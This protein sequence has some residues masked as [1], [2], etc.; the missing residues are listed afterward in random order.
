VG[1]N[2]ARLRYAAIPLSVLVLSLRNWRPLLPALIVLGLAI[3][4][5]VTPLVASFVHAE[6]DAAARESYWQ[7]AVSYLHSHLTPSYRVEAVDTAGHWP[8]LY[9]ARAGIP[10]ARGWFR[11]DDFPQNEVL[12]DDLGA[13]AYV[14]WLR[15]LGVKYVVLTDTRPDYSA[16]GETALLRSGRTPLRPVFA[17]RHLVVYEVPRATSILTGPPGAR[18]VSLTESRIVVAARRAGDYRLAVRWSRYWQP[19]AGC[20]T[21]SRD[22]M[23]RL[24]IPRP[25]RISLKFAPS[26]RSAFAALTGRAARSCGSE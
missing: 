19:S 10:L 13:K 7:P 1:E 16:R 12:Y 25:G 9:L 21:R 26:P 3:S 2:I 18:V 20:A 8:A 14:A 24:A 15:G 22:G 6:D 5:N 4:W 17:G 11:Q 23:I